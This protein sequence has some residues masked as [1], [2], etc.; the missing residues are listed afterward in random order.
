MKDEIEQRKEEGKEE[1]KEEKGQE[2]E[3]AVFKERK[4]EKQ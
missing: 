2:R 3:V 4:K 1:E